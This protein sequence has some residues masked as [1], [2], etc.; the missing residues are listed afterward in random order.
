MACP[1]VTHMSSHIRSMC[2]GGASPA[3][4]P[5]SS[6]SSSHL[7]AY[8]HNQ[9]PNSLSAG[10]ASYPTPHLAHALQSNSVQP[11][12]TRGRRR[13][14]AC[15]YAFACTRCACLS[16]CSSCMYKCMCMYV[17]ACAAHGVL[18]RSNDGRLVH[19]IP[20]HCC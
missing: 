9:S 5:P 19:P 10:G 20:S 7:G 13:P 15:A 17:F 4:S 8:Y 11:A 6:N 16:S 18:R 14:G 12:G 2:A 3:R 1:H